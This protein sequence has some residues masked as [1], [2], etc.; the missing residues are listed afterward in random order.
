MLNQKQIE[1][2]LLGTVEQRR[3]IVGKMLTENK[4]VDIM[5]DM[6]LVN[7]IYLLC[8]ILQTYRYDM[9]THTLTGVEAPV[10]KSDDEN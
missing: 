8:E 10:L 7:K 9:V 2:S 3:Q 4:S 5:V 6:P 1:Q